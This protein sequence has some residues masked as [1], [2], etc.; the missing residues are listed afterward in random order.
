ME[1]FA[2]NNDTAKFME[3]LKS[4][5]SDQLYALIVDVCSGKS[6]FKKKETDMIHEY[7]AYC[8]NKQSFYALYSG[9]ASHVSDY[10]NIKRGLLEEIEMVSLHDA[11][12]RHLYFLNARIPYEEMESYNII[13]MPLYKN[14]TKTFALYYHGKLFSYLYQF[15]DQAG[16]LAMGSTL[17][18]FGGESKSHDASFRSIVM[19]ENWFTKVL[20]SYPAVFNAIGSILKGC[21][22]HITIRL[23][24]VKEEYDI[25]ANL[26]S[27]PDNIL[28]FHMFCASWYVRNFNNHNLLSFGAS[29]K[30]DV[31]NDEAFVG[32]TK[33]FGESICYTVW[34]VLNRATNPYAAELNLWSLYRLTAGRTS[35]RHM[36]KQL[37]Q[38]IVALY[39]T[40][41]NKVGD[42]TCRQWLE[43]HISQKVSDFACNNICFNFAYLYDWT[44]LNN[45][46]EF[47]AT[48]AKYD[49]PDS[50]SAILF[51]FR[52]IS[53]MSLTYLRDIKKCETTMVK[54]FESFIFAC[55]AKESFTSIMFGI[56]YGLLC[57]NEKLGVIHGDLHTDNIMLEFPHS[58]IIKPLRDTMIYMIDE[59][60]IFSKTYI[61]PILID[62]GRSFIYENQNTDRMLIYYKTIFPEFYKLHKEQLSTTMEENRKFAYKVFSAFDIYML[63]DSILNNKIVSG[64]EVEF[65]LEIQAVAK[66]YLLEYMLDL[67]DYPFCAREVITTMFKGNVASKKVNLDISMVSKVSVFNSESDYSFHSSN[68]P[69]SCMP[70]R[71]MHNGETLTLPIGNAATYV[72]KYNL[73]VTK[74]EES[75]RDLKSNAESGFN[76]RL[77]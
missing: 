65:V 72:K 60:Y 8:A 56:L 25:H 22:E 66:K 74:N 48:N 24:E 23:Y 68:I 21:K 33:E 9:L 41:K 76:I 1:E 42:L 55:D 17:L 47:V 69:P 19:L 75:Y 5:K 40:E 77:L 16:T 30:Y 31:D 50:N 12:S 70:N 6:V 43:L 44:M 7:I 36:Y 28:F 64:K 35:E 39:G 13:N 29:E 2:M 11:P 27:T 51:V 63:C 73:R 32:L 38:K 15:Y 53:L 54:Y 46:D 45:V 58:V 49:S 71:I 67:K 20:N 37:G 10:T 59:L 34:A 52:K 4:L 57:L 61:S 26:M 14:D 3:H 62:F 18:C